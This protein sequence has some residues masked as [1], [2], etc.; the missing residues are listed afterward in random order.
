MFSNCKI[1]HLEI[2]GNVLLT[3]NKKLFLNEM[4][5]ISEDCCPPLHNSQSS[6]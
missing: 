5:Q 1:T 4:L 3:W 2:Y 6:D